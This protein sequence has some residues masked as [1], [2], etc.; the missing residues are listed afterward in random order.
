MSTATATPR[1]ES[2]VRVINGRRIER[3]PQWDG[4]FI[5]KQVERREP[6]T[7]PVYDPASGT[8]RDG[9]EYFE[10]REI[11]SARETTV[12]TADLMRNVHP[13]PWDPR[14]TKQDLNAL[15]EKS[16]GTEFEPLGEFLEAVSIKTGLKIK[17]WPSLGEKFPHGL[18]YN[19]YRLPVDIGEDFCRP[20]VQ[21]H[22]RGDWGSNGKLSDI[23]FDDDS[24]WCPPF[25]GIGFINAAAVELGAGQVVSVYPDV[26][27]QTGRH[28]EALWIVTDIGRRTICWMPS[29]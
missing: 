28:P 19:S 18:V 17:P 14:D 29:R 4:S 11:W 23:Q 25:F 10:D 22:L 16:K 21:K 8:T 9:I 13:K 20:F 6:I 27:H 12:D 3:F 1:H 26:W 15:I 7:R 5:W 24:R 2:G